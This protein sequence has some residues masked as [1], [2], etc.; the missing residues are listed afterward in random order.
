METS[1]ELVVEKLLNVARDIVPKV[2]NFVLFLFF[3][4]LFYI[5]AFFSISGISPLLQVSNE[6]EHCLT[7]VLSQNDPFRCLSVCIS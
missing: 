3:F 5:V 2:G 4:C 1:V 6:A 7:S